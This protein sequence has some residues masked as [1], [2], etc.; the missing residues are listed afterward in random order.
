M[1]GSL[2]AIDLPGGDNTGP[3]SDT[4]SWY[5][6]YS[7]FESLVSG[8]MVRQNLFGWKRTGI[9]AL[10]LPTVVE[11][12]RIEADFGYLNRLFRQTE[13]NR[14]LRVGYWLADR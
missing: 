10:Y 12:Y 1:V 14:H 8:C 9:G 5:N 13:G 3:L 7:N 11:N 2:K 6:I 4:S